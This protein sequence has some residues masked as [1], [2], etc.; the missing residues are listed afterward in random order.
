MEPGKKL[1]ETTN[2]GIVSPR[3]TYDKT[4]MFKVLVLGEPSVGK[5]SLVARY[6]NGLFSTKYKSTVGVDF[7]SKSIELDGGKTNVQ[8]QLWDLAGQERLGTQIPMFFRDARAAI[9]VFDVTNDYTLEMVEKWKAH[10]DNHC[11]Y[12]KVEYRPPTIIIGNKIDLRDTK[13][14]DRQ[15]LADLG[16]NL[17][18]VTAEYASVKL[19]I[20]FEEPIMKMVREAIAQESIVKELGDD[21]AIA[22]SGTG[23]VLLGEQ[24]YHETVAQSSS[25]WGCGGCAS[26]SRSR[27]RDYTT[28][29]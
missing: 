3:K 22:T 10:L 12:K 8:L 26:G 20:G 18:C 24:D 2:T 11:T 6:V 28:E 29:I 13:T 19:D 9:I 5:T 7:A 15:A 27:R 25:S 21:T 23:V 4:Y 17:G 16:A 1:D 14:L